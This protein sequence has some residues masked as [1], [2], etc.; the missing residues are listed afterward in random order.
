MDSAL[1]D[2]RKNEGDK[3]K[4]PL[5]VDPTVP[6]REFVVRGEKQACHKCSRFKPAI[7]PKGSIGPISNTDPGVIR[8]KRKCFGSGPN[9][10]GWVRMLKGVDVVLASQNSSPKGGLCPWFAVQR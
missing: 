4:V 8:K 7:K 1:D 3:A 9:S 5:I 6:D 2:A 10:C